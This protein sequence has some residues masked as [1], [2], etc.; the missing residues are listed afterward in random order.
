L[1]SRE[2]HY[3]NGDWIRA[4]TYEAIEV[5]ES[6]AEAL[7]IANGTVYGLVARVWS[8]DPARVERFARRLRAGQVYVNEAPFQPD[9]PFG[10][11]KES[12]IGREHGRHG[13]DEFLQT[14]ATVRPPGP[15]RPG[16][17]SALQSTPA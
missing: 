13:L 11:Y 3:V 15:P 12:G 8:D 16:T 6:E 5:D 14:K 9:A 1:I 2:R 4:L 7:A 17:A 10:G